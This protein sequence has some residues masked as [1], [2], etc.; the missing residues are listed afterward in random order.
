[1]KWVFTL[2]ALLLLIES[3]SLYLFINKG[4][5][6]VIQV[7]LDYETNEEN[8]CE[9]RVEI[10]EIDKAAPKYNSLTPSHVLFQKSVA[11]NKPVAMYLSGFIADMYQPPEVPH[12]FMV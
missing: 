9:S 4:K 3:T 2:I 1:M 12:G 7:L 6:Q 5:H 11:Y 10:T 8:S